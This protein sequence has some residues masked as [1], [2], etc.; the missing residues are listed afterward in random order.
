MLSC[1]PV[2]PTGR[3]PC[4]VRRLSSSAQADLTRLMAA[5]RSP[6]P[7]AAGSDS[8]TRR[9]NHAGRPLTA[10]RASST[11]SRSM[12]SMP[13]TAAGSAAGAGATGAGDGAGAVASARRTAGVCAAASAR[14]QLPASPPPAQF[15]LPSRSD[16]SSPP[17]ACGGR[18]GAPA[19]RT[20][21]RSTLGHDIA[22][23]GGTAAAGAR[24]P[25]APG[26]PCPRLPAR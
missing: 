23:H 20:L 1:M 7:H 8:R 15:R 2:I 26:F 9:W 19:H 25:A 24:R 5:S 22:L 12:P 17:L 13:L 16:A 6:G 3:T 18:V 11:L 14:C 21:V 4:T 10:S